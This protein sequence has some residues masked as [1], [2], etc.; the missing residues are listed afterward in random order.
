MSGE[1]EEEVGVG[2]DGKSVQGRKRP[3]I[4][5]TSHRGKCGGPVLKWPFLLLPGWVGDQSALHLQDVDR[6][7][8]WY[9]RGLFFFC[10]FLLLLHPS[11]MPRHL[12]FPS[13]LCVASPVFIPLQEAYLSLAGL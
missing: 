12:R 2:C 7:H 5:Q 8:P 3:T 10:C 4:R 11:S 6:H 1:E 13:L 9:R